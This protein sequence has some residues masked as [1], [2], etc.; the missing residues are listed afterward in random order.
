VLNQVGGV[1]RRPRY[2]GRP[3]A[4]AIATGLV[5]KHL[6]QLMGFLEDALA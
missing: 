4:A 2:A 3:A 6:A 5:S 1:A